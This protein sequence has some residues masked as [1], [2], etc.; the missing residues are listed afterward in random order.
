MAGGA[1]G[2]KELP[3]KAA[4]VKHRQE[5]LGMAGVEAGILERASKT[6]IRYR[7]VPDEEVRSLIRN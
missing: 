2:S 1:D 7:T 6:A 4:I 5:Q 3:E